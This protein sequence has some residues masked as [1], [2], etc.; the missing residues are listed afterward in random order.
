MPVSSGPAPLPSDSKKTN[1]AATRPSEP[2]AVG[3]DGAA[4]D[5]GETKSSVSAAGHTY[6]KGYGKWAKFDIDAALRSVDEVDAGIEQ[7]VGETKNQLTAA[8]LCTGTVRLEGFAL[9]G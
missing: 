9:D 5:S 4:G 7:E 3:N 8:S 6:D 1:S 2:S